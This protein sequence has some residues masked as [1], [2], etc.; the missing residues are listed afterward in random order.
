MMAVRHKTV[1]LLVALLCMFVTHAVAQEHV[2]L[3]NLPHVYIETFSGRSITSKDNYVLARMWMVSERDSVQFFDSLEIRGRGNATWGL[4]KKPYKL[5]FHEKEKLLGKGYANTKKWTLLANHGDKSLIRNAV[6]SA[7]GQFVGLKFNPAAK[8]VDLTLN[9]K[10]VGTYQFS[11]HV[12]VR[13]H[14]VNVVEQ[15]LPLTEE[16]NITGGY[17]LEADGFADFQNGHSGFYTSVKSVPIRIHYPDEDDIQTSQY[18]YIRNSVY[19]FEQRLFAADFADPVDGYRPRVDS[20][21]LAD[22]YVTC[23]VSGNPDAFWSTYFYKQQDDDRLYWGPLWDNDIAYGNDNRIGDTRRQL[24]RDV[25][26]GSSVLGPWAKRLWQ[27]E[28]FVR[29]VNRRLQQVND[30]GLTDFL[31]AKVDSLAQLLQRSQQLNYQRWGISTRTLRECVLYSTYDQYISD[32]RS[33]ISAHV[34]YLVETFASYLP[35]EPTPEPQ[36]D[37]KVPDFQADTLACYAI[38]NVATGTAFDLDAGAAN[39]CANAPDADSHSQQWNIRPLACGYMH[40]TNRLTGQ[41]LNDPTTGEPT[42]TTATGTALTLAPADS[43]DTRQQWDIVGQSGGRWNLVNRFSQHAA[44]LSGGNAAN[45]TRIISYTSD[46]RN[47]TS[48]NRLWTIAVADRLT[49]GIDSIVPDGT[50]DEGPEADFDYA[51]A[52][53]AAGARLH[54]GADDIARLNFMVRLYDRSGRLLRT[55]RACESCDLSALPRGLYVVSWDLRGR[56]HS[57]KFLK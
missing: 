23:E 55:F 15:D 26:F 49:D 39:V 13:P 53:D 56:R 2:R 22:W 37:P 33:Y 1:G 24:M 36:P 21:S 42:A 12:D 57:A 35:E 17:L 48:N 20:L 7:L 28:W 9:N 47:G 34:P 11:D 8:F 45:G 3:T 5:K 54:F 25:G 32:L 19:D 51:L 43:L 4:A 38:R 41:A 14:R 30:A 16:S 52:Y 29:L 44:N 18:R 6:T 40:I 50:V 27:D 31:L 10:Y 46:E